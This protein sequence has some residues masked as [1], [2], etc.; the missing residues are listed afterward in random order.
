MEIRLSNQE[1]LRLDGDARGVKISCRD[2][3]LWLTQQGDRTDHLLQDGD[4]FVVDRPGRVMVMALAPAV[5]AL[6]QPQPLRRAWRLD[7]VTVG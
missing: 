6:V 2:G 5:L 3:R 4:S 7:P 1:L